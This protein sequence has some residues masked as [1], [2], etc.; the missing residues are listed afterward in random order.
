MR[1]FTVTALALFPLAANAGGHGTFYT[2]KANGLTE[3]EIEVAARDCQVGRAKAKR[4][5]DTCDFGA[6]APGKLTLAADQSLTVE[7]DGKT[8]KGQCNRK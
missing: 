3:F 5:G 4:S 1:L 7:M 2:C 8:F 6:K